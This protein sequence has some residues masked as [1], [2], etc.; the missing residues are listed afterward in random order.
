MRWSRRR[1][2]T[3]ASRC[4]TGSAFAQARRRGASCAGLLSHRAHAQCDGRH[5]RLSHDALAG[6]ADAAADGAH[7]LQARACPST[8]RTAP[9]APNCWRRRSRSSSAT[10]ATSSAASSAPADSTRRSDITA[11]TVNRWPHGYAP[12]Y[13]SLWEP[14]VPADQQPHVVGRARFGRIA[15]ANSDSGGGAY[16]DVGHRPGPPRRRR[17]ARFPHAGMTC[18][19]A[20]PLL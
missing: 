17:A 20:R 9:A 19:G 11:I 2:S 13:N 4:A 6:R 1:W 3:P 18:P 14:M 7:P 16:T 5:R 15:I 8:T 12:E 10:S